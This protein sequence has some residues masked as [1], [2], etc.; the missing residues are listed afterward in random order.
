MRGAAYLTGAHLRTENAETMLIVDI[1]GT[2]TDVGAL[3]PSGFPRQAASFVEITG[4]RTNFAMPDV[5]SIG[6]GGGSRVRENGDGRVSVGPDS[7]GNA[8]LEESLI[9]GGKML[10]T[11]DVAV[12]QGLSG[13]GDASKVSHLSPDL[14]TK[15]SNQVHRILEKV[16]DK[17]K[18][19]K[20]D[21]QVVLVGG[22][23]II[24][25]KKINGVSKVLVPEF[26]TV[27]N[28]VGAA[29]SMVSFRMA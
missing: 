13:I 19:T 25:P 28:A 12:H 23:T 4:I 2:T 16:I 22:G 6:L 26:A 29:I 3:L 5:I 14:I 21:I 9:F 20:S 8:L 1:G 18:T 24:A 10:T 17:M 15:A 11:T 7:V 27:A